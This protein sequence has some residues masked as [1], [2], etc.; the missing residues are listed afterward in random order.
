M[1]VLGIFAA[2]LALVLNPFRASLLAAAVAQPDSSPVVLRPA[3]V[4][5][6]EDSAVHRGW[7]VAVQANLIVSVGEKTS[8]SLPTSAKIIDLPGMTLLPGLMDIHSHLLLHPYN[9]T[10]WDDQVLKEAPD[11][12]VLRAGKQAEATL[13][14]GFT[15]L[16]DLGTEGAGY[17]DVSIKKAINDGLIPGL[18]TETMGHPFPLLPTPRHLERSDATRFLASYGSSL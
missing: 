18:K 15:T 16:R 8:T 9:E 5:T 4:W 7:V 1:K 10:L 17:A 13:M 14:A 6:A 12:R 2:L 11:Y 3:G